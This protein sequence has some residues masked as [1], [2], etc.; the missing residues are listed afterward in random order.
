MGRRL[1]SWV[2]TMT[3]CLVLSACGGADRTEQLALE[4][5]ETYLAMEGCAA[6]V[7]VTADYGQRVYQYGMEVEYRRQGESVLTLT[8][9]EAVAGVTARLAQGETALEYDGTRVETGP[10]DPSGMSPVD[11]VPALLRSAGEGFMAECA[12]E[13][14]EQG[15]ALRVICRE[16]EQQAGTGLEY[17]LWFDPDTGALLRGE[18]SQDGFT[19]IQCVFSRFEP[20]ET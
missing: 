15:Q 7:E 10:L 14:L 6:S 1:A 11:A 16:P 4:I 18:L 2:L 5:R 3:L 19:V 12:M 17:S 9:P 13:E 20:L 8:A